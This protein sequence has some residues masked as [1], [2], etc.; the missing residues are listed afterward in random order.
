MTQPKAQLL[1]QIPEIRAEL[2]AVLEGM[3][4]CLDWRPDPEI[5]SVREVIS[6]LLNT[7]PGGVPSVFRGVM[8]GSLTEF[9]LWAD[10]PYLTPQMQE[11]DIAELRAALETCFAELTAAQ[12]IPQFPELGQVFLPVAGKEAFREPLG[13]AGFVPMAVALMHHYC[14]GGQGFIGNGFQGGGQFGKAGFQSRPQLSNV[15]TLQLRGQ[16]GLVSPQVKLG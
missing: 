16:I 2:M 7:P 8:D 6:H 1:A 5:W 12:G 14:G 11:W 3:D 9:D 10:Q 4:Y 15:P 13:R